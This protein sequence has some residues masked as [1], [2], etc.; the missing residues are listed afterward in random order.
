MSLSYYFYFANGVQMGMKTLVIATALFALSVWVKRY[1]SAGNRMLNM[2]LTPVPLLGTSG[3]RSRQESSSISLLLQ[4]ES[5]RFSVVPTNTNLPCCTRSSLTYR[6]CINEGENA[7]KWKLQL[8]LR[9]VN[10][11]FARCDMFSLA[12]FASRNGRMF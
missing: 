8:N 10:S 6:T 2:Q 9:L 5:T 3:R 11:S 7:S 1:F 4:T 12:C